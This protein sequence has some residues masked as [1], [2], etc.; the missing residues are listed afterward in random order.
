[1]SII[2]AKMKNIKPFLGGVRREFKKVV[3]PS[4]GELIGS[5]L[6]VLFLVAAFAVYLGGIDLVFGRLTAKLL[7]Y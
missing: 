7:S 2:G 1:M 3:W 6:V 4:K 5:T